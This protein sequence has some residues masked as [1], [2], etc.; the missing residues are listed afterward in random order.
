MP[1][2]EAVL[3]DY[4]GTLRDT[5]HVIFGALQAAF[6]HHGKD[7]PSEPELEPYIHHSSYVRKAFLSSM[8]QREFEEIYYAAKD[9]L[10][11]TVQLFAGSKEVLDDL[12]ADGVR[13]GLVT[14]AKKSMLQLGDLRL[15]GAFTVTV[16]AEDITEHKPSPEGIL[17]ALK[18]LGVPP[19]NAIYVG[20]MP[21]DIEAGKG[22]G[23]AA[24]VGAAYGFFSSEK[25]KDAG[26]DY[27]IESP[28][29]LPQLLR[30]IQM[31]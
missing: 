11:P 26:A 14:A 17:V 8:S 23:L 28:A 10:A 25:L 9:R 12:R 5:K 19:Q 27:I 24:T 22:A 18:R 20:D 2:I 1:K 30:E 13:T 4:D 21:T 15:E 29:E 6:Q 7:F 3:F 16:G 31:K